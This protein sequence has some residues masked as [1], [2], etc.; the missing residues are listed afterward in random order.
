M[1]RHKVSIEDAK[2]FNFSPIYKPGLVEGENYLWGFT[3]D[4]CGKKYRANQYILMLKHSTLHKI[5]KLS[6]N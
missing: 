4:Y 6:S 1:K 5:I 2:G 3:C